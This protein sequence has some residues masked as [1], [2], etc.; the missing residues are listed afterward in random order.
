MYQVVVIGEDSPFRPLRRHIKANTSIRHRLPQ[1]G[2][3]HQDK[4]AF[5]RDVCIRMKLDEMPEFAFGLHCNAC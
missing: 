2:V 5:C 1:M 4:L 3:E